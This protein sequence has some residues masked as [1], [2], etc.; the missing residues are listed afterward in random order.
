MRSR[1]LVKGTLVN[2]KKKLL[3][4]KQSRKNK[5]KVIVRLVGLVYLISYILKGDKRQEN[6]FSSTFIAGWRAKLT[7]IAAIVSVHD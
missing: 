4:V 5:P 3:E 1:L 6:K 7:N 2:F